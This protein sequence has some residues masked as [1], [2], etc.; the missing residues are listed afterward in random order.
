MSDGGG[1]TTTEDPWSGQQPYLLDVYGQAQ[2]Q[3]QQQPYQ[4]FG[5]QTYADFNPYQQQGQELM[6]N[7]ADTL[8]TGGMDSL[9]GANEQLLSGANPMSGAFQAPMQQAAGVYQDQMNPNINFNYSPN[10]PG[11]SQGVLENMSMMGGSSNPYLDQMVNKAQ[12]SMADVFNTQVMPN[13]RQDA[14]LGG[15]YGGSRQDLAT[16]RGAEALMSGMGDIASSMYG[17]AYETG[18]NRSLSAAQSGLGYEGMMQGLNLQASQTG[19]SA[20]QLRAQTAMQAAGGATS[21]YSTGY[22]TGQQG[23]I[24]AMG[25]APQTYGMGTMPSSLYSQVGAEQQGMEQNSITEAM[26]RYYYGQSAESDQLSRY[27]T[28]IGGMGDPGGTSTTGTE[29]NNEA[30]MAAMMMMMMA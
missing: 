19:L 3:S 23:Q 24:S 26:Q 7:Y 27:M 6:Q 9:F 4:Y 12:T 30:M 15:Q 21:G 5:G 18:M 14:I 10:A 16:N 2:Q 22:G 17:G 8:R 1:T 20:D 13:I 28:A 25:M 29:S 11:A